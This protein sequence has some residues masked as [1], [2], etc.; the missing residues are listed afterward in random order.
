MIV[1]VPGRPFQPSLMFVGLVKSL[2]KNRAP[3]RWSTYVGFGL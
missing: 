2:P 3:E 1:F